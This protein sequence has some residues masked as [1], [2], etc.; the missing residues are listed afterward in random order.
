MKGMLLLLAIL[1]M[2]VSSHG[3]D[4]TDRGAEIFTASV[5]ELRGKCLVRDNG[6]E[7]PRRLK[8]DDK[9]QAG[10]EL[11][12]EPKAYLKIRFRN[13]GAEK[14][15]KTVL[16]TWYVVPNVP[17]VAAAGARLAP[18]VR[19][20]G[21]PFLIATAEGEPQSPQ[22]SSTATASSTESNSS[23]DLAAQ[24]WNERKKY[25]LI[26]ASSKTGVPD[27]DLPF[28]KV[29]AGEI[30]KTL[31]RLGYEKIQV[32]DD[33][34]ATQEKVITALENI[35]N[36]DP[37]AL[38]V[39]YYSG[40]AWTDAQGR[41]LWLQLYGQ[42]KIGG[43]RGISINDLLGVARGST[44]AGQIMVILDTCYSGQAIRTTR[45]SPGDYDNTVIFASSRFSESAYPKTL[46]SGTQIS[47]F[48][49]H[50]I[51]GLN[52]DWNIVDG[53]GDGIILYTELLA[54]VGNQLVED[55]RVKGI[56]G[57]MRPELMGSSPLSW[58]A[59]DATRVHNF[60]TE[61]RRALHLARNLEIRDPEKVMRNLPDQLPVNA[62]SYHKALKALDQNKFSDA[63]GFLNEAEKEGSVSPAEIYWARANLMIEQ[64]RIGAA[65]DWLRKALEASK[66]RNPDLL[67]FNAILDFGFGDW[68]GAEKLFKQ[69]LD[70]V[71]DEKT[72]SERTVLSL[73]MLSMLNIF[74]GEVTEA[75]TYLEHLKRIDLK[76]IKGEHGKSE[77]LSPFVPFLEL[78]SNVLQDKKEAARKN[79]EQLQ[80]SLATVDEP[81]GEALRP[82]LGTLATAL[83]SDEDEQVDMPSVSITTEELGKWD[84][85]LS[86]SDATALIF[87]LTR[88]RMVAALP[89]ASDLFKAPQV[90]RLLQRTAEFANQHRT[91][92]QKVTI[93]DSLGVREI[94]VDNGEQFAFES[95]SI[96]TNLAAI[97]V[98]R[99]DPVS[100]ERLYK[101][102]IAMQTR[103]DGGIMMAILPTFELAE[104]YK[105]SQRFDDAVSFL[106]GLQLE[107]SQW[108]GEHH[109][110]S[111]LGHQQLGEIYEQWGK[112]E[113][114]ER[115]FRSALRMALVAFGTESFF[116]DSL[117]E[118]L[119]EFLAR[120]KRYEEA[121][122]LFEESIFILEKNK[123]TSMLTRE[124]LADHYL[125]LGQN[126][127]YLA[128]FTEAERSLQKAF[129]AH[130]SKTSVVLSSVLNC[131]HWQSATARALNKQAASDQFYN[132]M[133]ELSGSETAKPRPS[134]T[135][136][137]ELQNI[138]VWF[139]DVREFDKADR[140]MVQALKVQEKVYGGSSREVGEVWENFGYLSVTRKQFDVA[141][142]RLKNAKAIYEKH[143]S[144]D[145]QRMSTLLYW[146][147]YSSYQREEFE[148]ARTEL[149]QAAELIKSGDRSARYLLG[150]VQRS[151]G[152]YA[153][154]KDTLESVLKVDEHESRVDA[155]AVASDLM[156]LTTISRLAGNR[157][158]AD[159]WLN[160][161][162][163]IMK[164]I[165]VAQSPAWWARLNHEQGMAALLAGRTKDAEPL[166]R[167]AVTKGQ[168][169]F[170]LDM[171]MFTGFLNDY[172]K[173]LRLR[174]K[175]KEAVKA[176][177]QAK[178][179]RAQLR[180]I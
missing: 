139:R 23:V 146:L 41:D 102:A 158:E 5:R 176:E 150:K 140:L 45:L 103:L 148:Q 46:P 30:S 128:R 13:S 109:M 173:V 154:A 91:K 174:G 32:L 88:M 112:V 168:Q 51:E 165:D 151:L 60:K 144:P 149:Q 156:E 19:S 26:I 44:Y 135:L 84:E 57:T 81:W 163:T 98:A 137:S 71:R 115:S 36:L 171:V 21:N 169:A 96:L 12:C 94:D 107:I 2:I 14:E 159:H 125:N 164:G 142:T 70:S 59:Y 106:K 78:L 167:D 50:L 77:D 22:A 133:V 54:Y 170:D 79:F 63:A 86:K 34:N 37:D 93:T 162:E 175:D 101:E 132:Q 152:Q 43:Y 136:G 178:L 6:A 114:A 90:E 69:L 9:L 113:E 42:T 61:P 105:D 122:Q 35:P 80:S 53:D 85:V 141:Q 58:I 76:A 179:I 161:A 15:I 49:Y 3:Q 64:K 155:L 74:Q 134:K 31:T 48:T 104:L 127:F 24:Y 145:P 65:R 10:Q 124:S 8:P 121:A 17:A 52:T 138:A 108:L 126:Y 160:R 16:P 117:R 143:S 110:F 100:A 111:V 172:A 92:K 56:A 1:T 33:K 97:H 29:D 66:Q 20:K 120:R 73:L 180:K 4:A 38:V 157:V 27:T 75:T 153:I 87:L 95:A 25:F 67:A 89:N 83:S 18:A 119:A 123:S 68:I 47:A 55:S 11:Q 82:L 116:A 147:G 72:T 129:N 130:L 39:I 62:P 118:D 131:L 7:K 166:L 177:Q 99:E 28:A 40:H